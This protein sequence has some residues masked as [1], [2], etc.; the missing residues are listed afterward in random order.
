MPGACGQVLKGSLVR[1]QKEFDRPGAVASCF[2]WALFSW[3]LEE[4]QRRQHE[5]Q[6]DWAAM[7]V[8]G[9]CSRW[10]CRADRPRD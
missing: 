5:P 2:H 9:I 8:R 10:L 3:N 7:L 4:S 1:V 6:P